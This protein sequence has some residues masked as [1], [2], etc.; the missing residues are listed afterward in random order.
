VVSAAII[1]LNSSNDIGGHIVTG[2]QLPPLLALFDPARFRYSQG[3]VEPA[4]R[5]ERIT[6]NP[7]SL[8][9][10]SACTLILLISATIPA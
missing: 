7:F 2:S 5:L 10:T 4:S 9:P 3:T 6:R 8:V 1:L